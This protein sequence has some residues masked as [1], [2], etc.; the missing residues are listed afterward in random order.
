MPSGISRLRDLA[1][2]SL[3]FLA[4][5][6]SELVIGDLGRDGGSTV[7]MPSVFLVK[8]VVAIIGLSCGNQIPRARVQTH[9][10]AAPPSSST[11]AQALVV[12]PVVNTSSTTTI[13][14]PRSPSADPSAKARR[15]FSARWLRESN[16]W[17]FVGTTRFKA[18]LFKGI[19]TAWLKRAASRS[20][21]LNSRSHFFKE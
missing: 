4:K 20:A 14:F 1:A 15:T 19:W 9:T 8:E 18:R 17:V 2:V 21:W 12:A 3:G 7:S 5:A 10:S 16:V 11:F 13:C 6:V